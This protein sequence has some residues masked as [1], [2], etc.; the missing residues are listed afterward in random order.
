MSYLA[1]A[2]ARVQAILFVLFGLETE[3]PG[4]LDSA[5]CNAVL[6]S[7][8]LT[9]LHKFHCCQLRFY[10]WELTQAVARKEQS[11][12]NCPSESI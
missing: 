9:G 1:I 8:F 10:L 2:I 6:R 11:E 4:L 12:P 3:T 7:S 5:A